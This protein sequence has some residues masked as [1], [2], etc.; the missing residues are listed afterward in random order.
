MRPVSEVELDEAA[1]TLNEDG[2]CVLPRLFEPALIESWAAAFSDL[3]ARRQRESGGL[4]PRDRG[5]FYVT[6]PWERPF[7]DPH[8]FANPSILGVIERVLGQEH[9]LV[10]MGADTP[11]RGSD[12]QEVHRDHQP[13]FS[14]EVATPIFALAVNFPLCDVTE[15][16]GPLEMARGTH[17]TPRALALAQIAAGERLLESF[18]MRAGDV[19]IRAP[20]ALHRGTPNRTERPRPMIVLGYVRRWLQTPKVQL[21]VPR[22]SY[23]E[24]QPSTRELLRCHVTEH[25]ATAPE[26]YLQFKY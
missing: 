25:L 1:R 18:P 22:G 6:L 19:I 23:E 7:A 4:A 10:Q 21:M 12:Y 2:I 20:I 11:V 3:F 17:R 26:T 24:L 5:R 13:L 8:V 9:T 14:E 16:N 15:E